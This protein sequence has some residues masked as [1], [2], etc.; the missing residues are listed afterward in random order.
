V[1][2]EDGHYKVL[3]T[4]LFPAGIGLE[5]LDR[6][7]AHDLDTARILLDWLREDWHLAGGDDAFADAPF[8]RYWTKGKEGDAVTMKLAAA[9]ILSGYDQ[10]RPQGVAILEAARNSARN[11]AEKVN[12]LQALLFI[13]QGK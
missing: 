5:V 3:A 9:F 11:D 4:S 2:K 10:T 1:V 13:L 12:I 7:A 8:P 6:I